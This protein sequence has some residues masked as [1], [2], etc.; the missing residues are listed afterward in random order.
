MAKVESKR[1]PAARG[2]VYRGYRDDT[3]RNSGDTLRIHG[4]TEGRTQRCTRVGQTQSGKGSP[5]QR[6]YRGEGKKT[7]GGKEGWAEREARGRR[8][9]TPASAAASRGVYRGERRQ[10]LGGERQGRGRGARGR[11]GR[12]ER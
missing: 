8:G 1:A 11:G 3:Q 6:I 10:L 2:V 5:A 12:L 4:G 7:K 9:C